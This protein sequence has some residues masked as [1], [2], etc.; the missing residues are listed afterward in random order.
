MLQWRLESAVMDRWL[1]TEYANN[2]YR[3]QIAPMRIATVGPRPL[4]MPEQTSLRFWQSISK[5]ETVDMQN[6]R[7]YWAARKMASLNLSV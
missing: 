5:K 2:I 3:H 6:W 4:W 1:D 7:G